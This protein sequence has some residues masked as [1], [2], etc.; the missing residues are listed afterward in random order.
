MN[1][2][3]VY[4][5]Y[6]TF[7]AL[8]LYIILF[9]TPSIIGIYYSFT[10]WNRYS[11]EI[12][13]IGLENYKTIFSS[14]SNYFSYIY[15]TLR[16]TII[17]NIVK[18]IP[19]LFL[20]ILLSE[21]LKGED[22]HRAILFFPAILSYL[23]IGIIFRSILHPQMGI[24]NNM[25]RTVGLGLLAKSWLVDPK[26]VWTSI[27]AIDAWRG[28]GYVMTIFIAGLHSIP[29]Y[30][31]EAADIDGAGFFQK[32]IHITIPM[33]RPAI[34]INLIFGITYGLRVFDI[35]FV[36]TNGGPGRITEVIN[37]A[38]FKEFALGT[39]GVGSALSTILFIFMGL[40][41]ILLVRLMSRREVE[42]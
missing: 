41:S 6:F 17:S 26:W 5:Q 28:I 38:V 37:T 7:L 25:L 19:A 39:Y 13:F 35:I 36:L 12:K 40:I 31:Y 27:F 32:L 34:I 3:K 1:Q 8:G 24:L 42:L 33:L 29:R 30:Y 9:I 22:I 23:V 15:N 18:I 10:S 20:A 14:S 2:N 4:P 11:S 16:F 21:N